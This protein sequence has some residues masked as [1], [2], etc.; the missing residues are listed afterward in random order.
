MTKKLFGTDGIRGLAGQAPLTPWDSVR[1]GWA[2]GRVMHRK[3]PGENWRILIVRDT[4]QSGPMLLENL[5]KGFRQQGVDVF[6]GGVLCTPAVAHLVQA[7]RFHAGV[8]IS[9]SHNPP[10]FNGIKFFTPQ[11]R[12]WPDE[13]ESEVEKLFFGREKIKSLSNT[14][15]HYISAEALAIDYERFLIKTLNGIGSFRKLRLAVDCSN[16]ANYLMGPKLFKD[17]GARV[18]TLANKPTGKN[19]NIHCGSQHTQKLARVVKKNKCHIGVAFD[20]DGDRVIFVDEKG[21]EVDGDFIIA[22]LAKYLKKKKKLK[23]NKAVI[24]V[25]SN[26]GLRK[27]LEK[28]KI[29][30][31]VT[32]V[33]DRYVSFAMRSHK[34]VLGGEQSGHIILGEHLLT[35]DGLLTALHV[36]SVML[37]ADQPFSKL[38]SMM[39]KFP[40][41]LLNIVVAEKKPINLVRGAPETIA[42]IEKELGSNG[43][44]LVRYSGTEPLLRIMLEG[45]SEKQLHMYASEIASKFK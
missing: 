18:Y 1:L 11:G 19:I 16:G 25:M 13:W 37:E 20:G 41:V 8:V 7:H 42:K 9:A 17:L 40:Q 14:L 28:L 29:R 5:S 27:T 6:D 4:R 12:K 2:A 26:L 10:A 35:G 21:N 31:V 44:V 32:P 38:I 24:T 34:A 39:K 15:G 3:F 22:L 30:S 33:G 36:V 45:P 23:N 43:R